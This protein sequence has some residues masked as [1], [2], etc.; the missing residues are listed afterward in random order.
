MGIHSW[1]Q[2]DRSTWSAFPFLFQLLCRHL[3]GHLRLWIL[4]R[5]IRD[6]LCLDWCR[7]AFLLKTILRWVQLPLHLASSVS[8]QSLCGVEHIYW[9]F[10]PSSGWHQRS[11]WGWASNIC[12]QKNCFSFSLYSVHLL[13]WLSINFCSMQM[14]HQVPDHSWLE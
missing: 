13:T 7:M 4:L 6:T 1:C 3:L 8:L 5:K 2:T 9:R 14:S 10:P 12:G 11:D